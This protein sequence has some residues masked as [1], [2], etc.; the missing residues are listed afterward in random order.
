MICWVYLFHNS[1]TSSST[2][3]AMS[4]GASVTLT[5]ASS[6]WSTT[7][8]KRLVAASPNIH[9]TPANKRMNQPALFSDGSPLPSTVARRTR[10]NYTAPGCLA[11]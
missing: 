9:D 2:T 1:N 4:R 6:M 8:A 10:I 11:T 7:G 5:C 3:A